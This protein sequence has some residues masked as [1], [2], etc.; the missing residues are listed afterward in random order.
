MKILITG[1]RGF[2]GSNAQ[3]EFIK[4]GHEVVT[5]EWEPDRL[6]RIE[7]LDWVLHFVLL[8]VLLN[9]MSQR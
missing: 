9:V 4:L 2:I 1:N 3:R 5:Y 7:G 6:P 8:V